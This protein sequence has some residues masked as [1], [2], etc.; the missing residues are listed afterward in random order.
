MLCDASKV[1]FAEAGVTAGNKMLPTLIAL[2]ISTV[3][4]VMYFLRTVIRIYTPV[5]DN[6]SMGRTIRWYEQ[7]TFT[8]VA[9][10]FV[11]LNLA[12]GLHSQPV[13]N[14]LERGLA[15]LG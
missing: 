11:L 6:D 15:L 13:I 9:V 2:A 12:L 3:L 8:V 5:R 10:V 14:L 1:L 4:N 7:K